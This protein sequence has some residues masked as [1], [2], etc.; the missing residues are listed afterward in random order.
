MKQNLCILFA[1]PTGSSKT[2]IATYLSWNLGL[3]V[4]NNDAIRSEVAEDLG[5]FDQAVFEARRDARS[6]QLIFSSKSFIYDASID[7]EWLK[8][9]GWLRSNN[10]TVYIISLDLS[11]SLLEKMY[12]VKEYDESLTMLDR[13]IEDHSCFLSNYG[14]KVNFHITDKTFGDRLDLSLSAVRSMFGLA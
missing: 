1:G 11:R 4:F 8:L 9:D 6:K 10:Y 12:I 7:R 3:P 13:L 5:V 14:D 2:P